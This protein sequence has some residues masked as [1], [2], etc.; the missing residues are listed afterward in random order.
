MKIIIHSFIRP[1]LFSA[2]IFILAGGASQMAHAQKISAGG[3]H[4]LLICNDGT[5]K[6][7]GSNSYYQLGNN[8]VSDSNIPVLVAGLTGT[9]TA[10]SAGGFH[11]LA[12]KSD[13]SVWAWGNNSNGQLGVTGVPS[14]DVPVQVGLTGVIAISAGQYHSMALKSDGTVWTWGYNGYGQLG[15]STYNMSTIPV[16]TYTTLVNVIA[17]SAGGNHSMALKNDSTVWTWGQNYDGQ[18][19]LGTMYDSLYPCK[20]PGLT[21][22]IAID[23][24]GSH[25]LAVK[26]N[27]TV[28]AWG[29]NGNG[30]LG[31]G[32]QAP[33]SSPVLVNILNNVVDVSAGSSHCLALK[34]DST[35]WQW[36][37]DL[38][39]P[40]ITTPPEGSP[41]VV[42][43]NN[44]AKVAGLSGIFE[45]GAGNIHA[46]AYKNNE[47]AFG[48]G[49]NGNGQLG[50]GNYN[51]TETPVMVQCICSN[52]FPTIVAGADVT[53]CPG[54]NTTITGTASGGNGGPF[55]YEWSPMINLNCHTCSNAVVNPYNAVTY[56]VTGFDWKK[57]PAQLQDSVKVS[58]LIAPQNPIITAAPYPTICNSVP[59]TLTA[60]NTSVSY[61][62]MPG[63]STAS[64]I[65]VIPT[66]NTY[67]KLHTTG[68][69]GCTAVDSMEVNYLKANLSV[70]NPN[71]FICNG[72]I[73]ANPSGGYIGGT[74]T[75]TYLWSDASTNSNIGGLCSNNYTVTVTD[76]NGCT[77]SESVTLLDPGN[78]AVPPLAKT[79]VTCNG[80]GDGT[81]TANPT[82]GSAPNYYYSWAP[83]NE[84]TQTVTGL[85]PGTYTVT[86]TDASA[87]SA[88]V[89]RTV[90]IS[91]PAVLT[92]AV[93]ASTNVSCNGGNNGSATAT[94]TGGKAPY[95]YLWM[96]GGQTDQTAVNLT[97]GTYT[98]TVKDANNCSAVPV[99]KSI[100]QPAALSVTIPTSSN[101]SCFG[102]NNGSATANATGGTG[103]YTYL[104]FPTG[105]VTQS[106][107]NLSPTTHTIT[108]KDA[109]NCSAVPATKNIIQPLAVSASVSPT[110]PTCN[111]LCNGSATASTSGGISPYSYSWSNGQTTSAAI[112]LCATSYTVNITDANSCTTPQVVTL[113][114]P[115]AISASVSPANP[116]C[117][118]LCNGSA[119]AS[120]SG[121]ISPYSYSWSNGQTTSAAIGLCATSYTVTI[122]D[123]NGCTK[124]QNTALTQPAA[125]TATA[126]VTNVLCINACDGAA[127]VTPSGGINP[128]SFAWNPGG[129]TTQSV[130]GLCAGTYSLTTTDVNGCSAFGSVIVTQPTALTT[131]ITKTDAN[132]YSTCTGTAAVISAG[133]SGSHSYLWLPSEQVTQTPLFLCAGT[134]T[135][136]ISDNNN[137]VK[138]DTITVGQP[139]GVPITVTVTPTSCGLKSGTAVASVSGTG[140][141]PPFSY[142]WTTG[143]IGTSVSGLDAG[144][145]R[146]NV[147]DGNG[148]FG[149]ADAFVTSSNG[150]T[151]TTGSVTPV[152]CFG[153]SDGAINIS[154][155]GGSTPYTYF[156]SNGQTT[157]DVSNL[158]YGPYEVKVIDATGC[159]VMKNI[160]V[161]QPALLS[162]NTSTIASGCAATNG[163]ASVAVSGGISPYTYLWSAGG[164]TS[165]KS[166]LGAGIYE[167]EV[168]DSN[169]CFDSTLIAV[170][171]SGGPIVVVDTIVAASCGGSGFVLLVPQ[172]SAAIAA[173]Q[174]NT[175]S[176]AQNLTNATPGNYGV[177]ITDT[178]GCKSV[179]ITPV[180]P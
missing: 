73:Y 89:T 128:Y 59:V 55:S 29:N 96:P 165:A 161:N 164:T 61:Y 57:C 111:N 16:P 41:P 37:A 40:M 101:V 24:G 153:L 179:L 25:S 71:C 115:A 110:N 158:S 11:S 151:I 144:I 150:P 127:T 39:M 113:T 178:S 15:D 88:S 58:T 112:G 36:G 26:N 120:T 28:L 23:G 147:T 81:A 14:S 146:I 50:I 116:T 167:V 4:S 31:D 133:G 77:A 129:F 104:W 149:F 56:T 85:F 45:I 105:Q 80:S 174:W 180:N 9:V 46:L 72:S 156:W 5:V 93:S 86:V 168:T 17:I 68:P 42:L 109:N 100:T 6:A 22:V 159:L 43:A 155:T 152:S 70:Y 162:L 163:S 48:W 52:L 18:L 75:Y 166:A 160:F 47:T 82:G 138:S 53:I 66:S 170:Q 172:D 141:I 136:L 79:D 21:K 137:C 114:Q 94:A 7:W 107:S 65:V 60:S 10:V 176:T 19:G 106:I 33:K 148:C 134:H 121:G 143:S 132:C 78:L 38:P 103:T 84:Y 169:G 142:L 44:P 92:S 8:T 119:T 177:V 118:N 108:V 131:T 126:S 63:G 51:D 130:S 97:M 175:G 64:T 20:V 145:Y 117:N 90:T 49:N 62:W 123:M 98:V 154:V 76:D 3:D 13:G 139:L 87:C 173:Y 125:L 30:Q 102:G 32:T 99:V 67:Y 2:L 122:T 157:E 69:N 91:Q 34:S 27:G 124:S 83:G 1:I 74:F 135:V 171:D 35:V 54:F 12:L 95:T 140:A